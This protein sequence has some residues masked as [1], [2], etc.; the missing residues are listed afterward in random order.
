ML[1]ALATKHHWAIHQLDV[2]SAF[3]NGELKEEVYLVQPKGFV[4]QVEEH[5]VYKLNKALYELKQAP[6]SW[7]DKIDSFFLQPSYKR[8]KNDHNLYTVFDENGQII[9]ISL[10]V[11]DLI[12][13]RKA[14]ELIKEIKEQ[15]S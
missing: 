12:I 15:M 3:L 2:K 8:S 6:R 7:Y 9:L 5:L 14:D 10:Y 13:T 11:D 1:I 4:K